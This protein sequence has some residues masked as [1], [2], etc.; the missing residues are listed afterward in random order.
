MRWQNNV[1][2]PPMPKEVSFD[3]V[4]GLTGGIACGKTLI[5]DYM[6]SYGVDVID[7]DLISRRLY[8]PGSKLLA[9]I[10][11]AFGAEVL[12]A[13]GNLNR[14]LMR[15]IVFADED[16][17]YRL[18]RIVQ[19][20]I[21][22]AITTDLFHSKKDHQFLVVPLLIEGGYIDLCD[23]VWVV[24]VR[25]EIQMERLM[26]RD[27]IDGELARAMIDSQ[28]PYAVKKKYADRVIDNNGTPRDT[29][30]QL[31]KSFL[32]FLKKNY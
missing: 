26:A 17:R 3:G 8:R 9:E 14:R 4:I 31:R 28:M 23:E 2:L 20:A 32:K 6:A 7:G 11:D 30:R 22:H 16:A 18:N 12:L 5:S 24:F 27:S 21:R 13:D 10:A 29:Y 15:E 19:P 25:E 1:F